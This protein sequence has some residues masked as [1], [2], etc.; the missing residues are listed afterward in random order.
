MSSKFGLDKR[1]VRGGRR[2]YNIKALWEKHQ[3]IARQ[4]VLGRSNGA[5][6]AELGCTKQVV[7]DVRNSPIGQAEIDRLSRG[8]DESVMSISQRIE[9]FAPVALELIENIVKGRVPGASIAL[10]A[11][12]AGGQLARAGY[13]EVR[14]VQALHAHLGRDDI[15]AI[16]RRA[17]EAGDV[18]EAEIVRQS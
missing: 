7:S 9:E 3:E 16:K 4:V 1:F 12:L 8:R 15:E 5:I 11:K 14:K 18:I 17:Q 13:G 2:N 6:A 10:R